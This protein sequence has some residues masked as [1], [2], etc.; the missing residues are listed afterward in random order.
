M[1]CYFTYVFMQVY[2]P[3]AQ[4]L[5]CPLPPEDSP[6]HECIK[7][8][9]VPASVCNGLQICNFSQ[10]VVIFSHPEALC[11]GQRDGNFVRV[12]LDCV[13]GA[14]KN[15][16]ALGTV[17]APYTYVH[18]IKYTCIPIKHNVHS[19][20]RTDMIKLP[21]LFFETTLVSLT[22]LSI[23]FFNITIRDD[24]RRYLL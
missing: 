10:T 1:M 15:K 9:G 17:A 23:Q 20:P 22:A 21:L 12:L 13:P 14:W 5:E 19:G 24:Q 8:T 16:R 4:R 7:E 6:Y 11:S 3:N 18:R 2:N